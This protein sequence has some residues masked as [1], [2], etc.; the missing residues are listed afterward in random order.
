MKKIV[1]LAALPIATLIVSGCNK[2]TI[3]AAPGAAA[4]QLKTE[5]TTLSG[6]NATYEYSYDAKGKI[7]TIKK[8]ASGVHALLDS[9]IIGDKTIVHYYKSSS[10]FD[11]IQTTEYNQSFVDGMPTEAHVALQEG[12]VTHTNVYHYFFF[13]DSKNRLSKV[14]E[15][16]DLVIGDWEY[17]LSIGYDDKDNVT[18]LSY[19]W[20]TGPNT[21]TT[22]ASS[23]YDD[24][25]TPFAGIKNWY[26]FMHAGWDNYDPEPLFTA[27]SKHN[28]LGYTMPDGFKRS[29]TYTYND[30]GFPIVRANTNTNAAGTSTYSFQETYNYQ[31]K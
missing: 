1:F 17:D 26:F 6:N 16:T 31:C 24:K 27:L 25:P 11:M 4:C 18:S 7:T 9:M 20:T 19:A 29:I 12:A 10:G 23:G 28:P 22:I 13:Y 30:K 2:P 5:S 3:P 21:I 14:G 15:Q 8:F